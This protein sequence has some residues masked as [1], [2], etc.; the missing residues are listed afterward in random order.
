[1]CSSDLTILEAAAAFQDSLE[2]SLKRYFPGVVP[3]TGVLTF[4]SWVGGDRD[5]NPH[6][7]PNTSRAALQAHRRLILS[8]YANAVDR[9]ISLLSASFPTAP[10][11]RELERNVTKDLRRLP[12]VKRELLVAEPGE[13][14][15]RKLLC[16]QR[17]LENTNH[18]KTPRYGSAQEFLDDLALIQASL[19]RGRGPRAAV[20]ELKSLMAQ[21][22]TFGFH[23]ACLDFRQHSRRI[24]QT[25]RDIVGRWPDGGEWRGLMERPPR[26][27]P[28]LPEESRR[29]LEEFACLAGLQKRFGP[30]SADRYVLSMTTQGADVWAVMSLARLAGLIRRDNASGR[31]RSTLDVVPLFET[32]PDLQGAADVMGRLWR[33]PLYR[34]ILRSRKDTQEIMLGYSD[35]NKDGGYLA[36]NFQLYK[37]QRAL[38]REARSCGVTLRFFHGKGGTIDRG[39]GPAHRAILAMPDS[40]PDF[41]LRITEQGEAVSY[42]YSHPVIARRNFEQMTSAVLTAGLIPSDAGLTDAERDR[43]ESALAEIAETSC[44]CY[45]HLVYKTPSFL[46]YFSQ[47]TP[48]DVIQM[49]TIASRPVFRSQVQSLEELRAIPW[50]FAWTQSRHFLPA[51]YGIGTALAAYGKRYGNDGWRLLQ[52]MYVRWPFF[53]SIMDNA[54]MSLAKADMGIAR[55]YA[56]LVKHARVRDDIFEKIQTEYRLSVE[57]TL[58]ACGQR[59]LLEKAP[60][61]AESIRLRNPYV[62]SLN[63][64]QVEYLGRWRR[65]HLPREE[66]EALLRV[67]LI[68]VNGVAA[69]MKSTG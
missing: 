64:L 50:V 26:V 7:T 43:F 49:T 66:R 41:H 18:D 45:R 12:E 33:D 23:L 24:R 42:K 63:A 28:R 11:D 62:D 46:T 10:A 55:R 1:M 15:R 47:A 37:T 54:Q 13:F 39:G 19:A 31:W 58:R 14:Y 29:T 5:G 48:I 2:R 17:R 36:A 35:S 8:Y 38:H 57:Q 65:T 56:G 60:V 9:L 34:A 61:L 25:L 51:W 40:A 16:I 67:L 53:S 59:T 32:I 21:V 69:G 30:E 44:A 4:G 52:R 20:G 68:T 6:V 22:R 27:P 3:P